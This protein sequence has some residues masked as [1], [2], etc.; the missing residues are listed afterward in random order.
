MRV[1]AMRVHRLTTN[2]DGECWQRLIAERVCSSL[3]QNALGYTY[4]LYLQFLSLVL[5]IYCCPQSAV[6]LSREAIPP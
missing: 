4:S 3:T 2:S 1:Q 5:A 6:R